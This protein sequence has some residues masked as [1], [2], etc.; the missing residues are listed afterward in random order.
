MQ[1]SLRERFQGLFWGGAIAPPQAIEK[2]SENISEK[3]S[4]PNLGFDGDGAPNSL[5]GHLLS[6]SQ[7][8]LEHHAFS[9]PSGLATVPHRV[10]S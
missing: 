4:Q 3:N 5:L 1:C 9:K 10:G 6:N 2:T 7:S 8:L